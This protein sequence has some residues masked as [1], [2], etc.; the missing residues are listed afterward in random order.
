MIQVGAKRKRV[1]NTNE[2]VLANGRSTRR[3]ASRKRL[4]TTSLTK[5][6]VEYFS[7]DTDTNMDTASTLSSSLTTEDEEESEEEASGTDVEEEED[8]E[9]SSKSIPADV[10][11]IYH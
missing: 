6:R 7:D 9:S 10:D 1:A 8:N 3:P 5:R 11:L 4:K 2:N